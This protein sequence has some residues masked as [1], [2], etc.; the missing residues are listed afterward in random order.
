MLKMYYSAENMH[1]YEK[2]TLWVTTIAKRTELR[3]PTLTF[4][5]RSYEGMTN[6]KRYSQRYCYRYRY[7]S[8]NGQGQG[9]D[10]DS[11]LG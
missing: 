3:L 8:G 6:H 1:T 11:E 7:R 10:K 4:A 2:R 9:T 5:F